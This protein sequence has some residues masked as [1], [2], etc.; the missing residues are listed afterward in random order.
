MTDFPAHNAPVPQA[1]QKLPPGKDFDA[2]D[3]SGRA[4]V[5]NEDGVTRMVV[6]DEGTEGPEI[7]G[8]DG[9]QNPLDLNHSGANSILV[10][11]N[12]SMLRDPLR[13]QAA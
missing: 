13:P 7:L 5:A 8:V 11:P 3:D 6:L 4:L 10:R 12:G 2:F 9:L 1:C